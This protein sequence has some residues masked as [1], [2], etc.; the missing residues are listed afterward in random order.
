MDNM[1]NV[2]ETRVIKE[3]KIG[4][5]NWDGKIVQACSDR[6]L[7]Q[8]VGVRRDI[9]TQKEEFKIR[10]YNIKNDTIE[11]T[12]EINS[13]I[14]FEKI[15]SSKNDNVFVLKVDNVSKYVYWIQDSKVVTDDLL[16]ELNNEV[17]RLSNLYGK[18]DSL[19]GKLSGSNTN[20]GNLNSHLGIDQ[21]LNGLLQSI[22]YNNN[23]KRLLLSN[24][25]G[26]DVISQLVQ[27][28]ELIDE[29]KS[30][31]PE[32]Q[33]TYSDVI[34][35][36]NCPQVKYTLRLLDETIY[37]S[38]LFALATALG[39][40]INQGESTNSSSNPMVMFI[41]SLDNKYNEKNKDSK[42]D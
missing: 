41:N 13:G 34:H 20:S 33:N 22:N 9:H 1:Y 31:M 32:D 29:L 17:I 21:G 12:V 28:N 38:Q 39:L 37:S 35:A 18:I 3:C 7:L 26:S 30:H 11:N 8:I 14:K 6:G 42:Q 16:S 19:I 24:I 4:K 10:W 5:M 25:V 36:I 23:V 2:L 40:N 15:E 27:D